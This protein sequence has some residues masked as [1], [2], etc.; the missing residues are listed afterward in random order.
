[1]KESSSW[2]QEN[3]GKKRNKLLRSHNDSEVGLIGLIF[4]MKAIILS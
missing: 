2:D 1:M 4:S 3:I